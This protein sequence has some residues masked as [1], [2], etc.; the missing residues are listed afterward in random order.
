MRVTDNMKFNTSV[1][2]LF[3]AQVQY[4]DVSEK[5]ASQ[6]KINRASDDPVGATK[7]IELNRSIAAN[8][9]YA[10]NM[11]SCDAWI[12][13]TESKLS[14]AYDLLVNAQEIAVA[15]ATGTATADTRKTAADTIQSIIDE[16]GS[17]AN[18]KLGDRSL[19][20]GSRSGI[21]PFSTTGLNPE[22]ETAEAARDNVFQGTVTSSGTYTGDVNTTY[23]V[24]ITH[25][26]DL[27]SATCQISTDGGRT[28]NGTDLSLATGDISLG[29]GVILSFDDVGGTESFGTD[30]IFHVT[31]QTGGFYRGNTDSLSMTINRGTNIEYSCNGAEVFTAEGSYGIDV[32]ETL[33]ALKEALNN[34]DAQGISDQI[35]SLKDA[36]QQVTIHQS[37][38]GTRANH[39]EIARNNLVELNDQ[40]NLLLSNT[41][42]ADIAELATELSMKEIALQASYA[43]AVKVSNMT[44]LD[45]IR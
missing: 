3:K 24:K 40:L 20:S 26:G 5:L 9:Q 27:A 14:G 44:I 23:A 42:D 30:D 43:V 35:D 22:I 4:N 19:F 29:N 45:F 6:K 28:W 2:N 31:A 13:A 39:I 1:N 36:Q 41:Q 18:A 21:E 11:D 33:N 34:N 16:M 10:K 17:L 38:C 12:S 25:A 15:Q 32:F 8:E 7:I 37:L